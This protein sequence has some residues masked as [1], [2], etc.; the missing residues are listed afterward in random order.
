MCAVYGLLVCV[1]VRV[2]GGAAQ[3]LRN[4]CTFSDMRAYR[5]YALCCCSCAVAATV[6]ADAPQLQ[7][8]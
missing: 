1:C 6:R 2:F 8:M 3:Q 5:V 7:S 4:S